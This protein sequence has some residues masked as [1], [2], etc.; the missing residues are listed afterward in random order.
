MKELKKQNHENDSCK[1][2]FGFLFK[3]H[4][5]DR[6]TDNKGSSYLTKFQRTFL[7][8]MFEKHITID[9]TC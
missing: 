3:I 1:K 4:S 5:T 8:F 9:G 6:H 7:D 2:P